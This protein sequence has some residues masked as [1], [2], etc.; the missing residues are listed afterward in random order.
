MAA[1]FA[2]VTGNHPLAAPRPSVA[3]SRQRHNGADGVWLMDGIDPISLTLFAAAAFAASAIAGLAGFAFGLIA[4]AFWLHLLGPVETAALIVAFGL[5]IQGVSVWKLRNAI[6]VRRLLPFVI[7][8]AV[9]VP[10]GV[11]LLHW[12]PQSYMRIA[13]GV[14]L[15]AYSTYAFLQPKLAVKASNDFI[16][17][18][19]G[20]LNGTLAGATGLAGILV[21]IWC[22][23]RGWA[24][25]VQ[26]AIFQPVAVVTFAMTA[27]WLG[28]AGLVTSRT[29]WLFVVGLP[30]VLAGT[31]IGLKLYGR[32]D[33]P[34][35]RKIVLALLFFSG[36]A[37]LA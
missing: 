16:D 15:L 22:T 20:V 24:K 32:L 31:W 27:V 18:L 8:S 25:D 9:G 3:L 4:A 26:R 13:V 30:A 1:G 10:F 33:E 14:F 12:V 37:L 34:L 6:S 35:F 2:Q 21:V 28:T 19:V 17:S 7:G 11:S 36:A 23:S 5:L 29:V